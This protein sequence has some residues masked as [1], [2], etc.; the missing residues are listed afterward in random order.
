MWL[1]AY[2]LPGSNGVV[3]PT[4]AGNAFLGGAAMGY[5]QHGDFA[6]AAMYGSEA[7]SFVVEKVGL[8]TFTNCDVEARLDKYVEREHR[9]Q[10][11]MRDHAV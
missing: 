3:D 1:P 6:T 4:G 2:H 9:S 11:P 5:L 8:P 7:A 10:K